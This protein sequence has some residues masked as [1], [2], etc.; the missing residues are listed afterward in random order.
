M[1]EFRATIEGSFA[2]LFTDEMENAKTAIHRALTETSD[3]A[4]VRLRGQVERAGM[5]RRL[6]RTWRSAVYPRAPKTSLGAAAE[7][8][9]N[10]PQIIRAF[11]E[12]KDIKSSKGFFLA[13]PTENAPKVAGDRKRISPL[14]FPEHRFGPLRFVYRRNGPSLLVVDGVR[15]NK[16]GKVG[17]QL[18]NKGRLK[19]GRFAKGVTTVVMFF[20]VP[21]VTPRKRLDVDAIFRSLDGQLAR[22]IIRQWVLIDGR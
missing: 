13:I 15:I 21:K 1:V 5:G 22:A 11:S 3:D 20:L 14:N 9:S 12:G 19:S 4:K 17:R 18:K 8:W 7:V 10:A 6:A 2:E 16:S